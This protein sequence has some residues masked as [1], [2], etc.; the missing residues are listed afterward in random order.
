MFQGPP[1]VLQGCVKGPP[2][3]FQVS[4]RGSPRGLPEVTQG[5]CRDLPDNFQGS[6]RRPP[7]D[8]QRPSRR[9]PMAF[10]GFFREPTGG[11]TGDPPRGSPWDLPGNP[12]GDPPVDSPGALSGNP[13]REL[14]GTYRSP[15]E[16]LHGSS[17]GYS[18]RGHFKVLPGDL[19]ENRLED[20]PRGSQRLP[21]APRGL[22]VLA[23]GIARNEESPAAASLSFS[24]IPEV[25]TSSPKPKP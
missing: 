2:L 14:K 11:R 12:P 23:A 25:L 20:L 10:Q 4:Y 9:F 22:Q 19:S 7:G 6:H 1:E 3:V 21:E 18:S 17:N 5:L 16:I 24:G 15:L 13:S 8:L